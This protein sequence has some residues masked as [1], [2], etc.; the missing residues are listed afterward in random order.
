MKLVASVVQDPKDFWRSYGGPS[1][2]IQYQL[3]GTGQN[4][5]IFRLIYMEGGGSGDLG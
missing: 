3:S 5:R 1:A 2:T 4:S